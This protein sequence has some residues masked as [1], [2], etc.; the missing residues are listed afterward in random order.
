LIGVGLGLGDEP[1]VGVASIGIVR[2][3]AGGWGC[4]V[5][6]ALVAHAAISITSNPTQS[7]RMAVP[8]GR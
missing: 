3:G 5:C 8:Y 6:P 4:L 1:V 7:R 2:R